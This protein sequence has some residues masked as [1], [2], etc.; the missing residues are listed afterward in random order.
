[1]STLAAAEPS[2]Q[3]TTPARPIEMS[4]QKATVPLEAIERALYALAV[5]LSGEVGDAGDVWVVLV[6]PRSTNAD[7]ESLAHQMRQAVTDQVLRVR[8][9][10]RTDPVRNLVFA[11]AFS[12]SGLSSGN[13]TAN[14]A[15]ND[16]GANAGTTRS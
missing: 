5:Q 2:A 9:A 1:M 8:I 4:W 3:Q 16:V 13:H 15:G 7:R 11:L 14:D 10:E 12:R 6:H